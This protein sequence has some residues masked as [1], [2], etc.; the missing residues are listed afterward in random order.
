[1]N[2]ATHHAQCFNRSTM[3]T[4][5]R[6]HCLYYVLSREPLIILTYERLE[7]IEEMAAMIDR[8]RAWFLVVFKWTMEDER[9]ARELS[10]GYTAFRSRH[11]DQEIVFLC[12]TLAEHELLGRLG[13]R[14][15][16]CSQNALLDEK[17]YRIVPGI[18]K[19]FD[20][21]YNAQ[22]EPFKRHHL[23][24]EVE[25]LALIT[26]TL[27]YRP[28]E[29]R[30]AYFQEVRR[31]LPE[32]RV[33]NRP[34]HPALGDC[35]FDPELPRIPNHRISEHLATARAGLIL[36]AEEGA[37]WAACEYLLSGLPV[38]STR[39]KGGRDVL[40]DESTALVVEDSAEAVARGLKNLIERDL[41]A[42]RVRGTTLE[43]V[44]PHRQRFVALINDIY[45][46]AGAAKDFREEWDR[47][48]VNRMMQVRPWPGSFAE[49]V[50][51]RAVAR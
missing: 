28:V 39:S 9:K 12:N 51:L 41:P 8:R 25:S 23:A 21:V 22:L 37:C 30:R 35:R 18:E 3:E 47:V 4:R 13:L 33:L 49:D 34:G 44:L 5:A 45:R 43:K 1:M 7:T 32:A 27:Y 11:P 42:E 38:V 31:W 16:Y 14:R 26:Y 20:A 6:A 50:H 17:V 10:D 36:S 2:D 46:E 19:R 29:P 24:C 40:F 15:I 48:F